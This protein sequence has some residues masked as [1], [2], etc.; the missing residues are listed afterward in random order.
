MVSSRP[1]DRVFDPIRKQR[2]TKNPEELVRQA[3]LK[4]MTTDL[5]YPKSL[6]AVEKQLTELL[7][8]KGETGLPNRRVDILCYT[9]DLAPLLL[10][11]CKEGEFGDDAKAQVIGYNHYIQAPFVALAGL[12]KIELIH[13]VEVSFLPTY[14]QLV[15]RL[16]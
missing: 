16:P 2:V 7:H 14:S 3:L 4:T 9:R 15:E 12:G 13:P 5:G 11:E 1:K 8:L 6:I 10:I